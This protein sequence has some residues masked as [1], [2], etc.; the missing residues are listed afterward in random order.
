M[1]VWNNPTNIIV[2]HNVINLPIFKHDARIR[3]YGDSRIKKK[4]QENPDIHESQDFF[5]KA[6]PFPVKQKGQAGG[7]NMKESQQ[8]SPTNHIAWI[9]YVNKMHHANSGRRWAQ[10]SNIHTA[11]TQV[12]APGLSLVPSSKKLLGG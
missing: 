11:T 7:S 5:G 9:L 3:K 4:C 10:E 1:L 6:R 8:E 2:L 12:T